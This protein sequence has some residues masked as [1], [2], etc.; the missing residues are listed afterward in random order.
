MAELG[1]TLS[2]HYMYLAAAA[3]I[4]PYEYFYWVA[5]VAWV[6]GLCVNSLASWMSLLS[7]RSGFF[8]S[9]Y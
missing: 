3:S 2:G 9:G 5:A 8:S 1:P 6:S 7:L 4:R